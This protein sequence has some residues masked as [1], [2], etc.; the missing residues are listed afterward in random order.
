[1][2]EKELRKDIGMLQNILDTYGDCLM[3][4]KANLE[5]KKKQLQ[6]LVGQQQQF[7]V[8]KAKGVEY[9]EG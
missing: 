5:A 1:M 9:N 8:K 4:V 3:N 2:T 7:V 6:E